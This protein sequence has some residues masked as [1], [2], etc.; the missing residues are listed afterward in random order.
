MANLTRSEANRIVT[1]TLTQIRSSINITPDWMSIAASAGVGVTNALPAFNVP[2]MLSLSRASGAQMTSMVQSM[3]TLCA[4]TIRINFTRTG[5]WSLRADPSGDQGGTY[6]NQQN[7]LPRPGTVNTFVGYVPGF[8][9]IASQ[10]VPNA[11]GYT[12]FANNQLTSRAAFTALC[13]G[14]NSKLVAHMNAN[15]IAISYC[16][17][18]CHNNCHTS[19]GRR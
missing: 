19:R 12:I 6:Y 16:H 8:T 2:A 3:T 7:A 4:R 10:L 14:L 15:P 1:T 9:P 17:T 18:N 5:T 13:Q 11:P